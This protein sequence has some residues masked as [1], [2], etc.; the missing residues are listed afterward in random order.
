MTKESLLEAINRLRAKRATAHGNDAEQERINQKLD[1]L[2]NKW[3][4]MLE[5]EAKKEVA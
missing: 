2:Y 3:Y 1:L 4:L 5:Q